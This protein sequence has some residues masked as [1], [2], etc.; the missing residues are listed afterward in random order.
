MAIGGALKCATAASAFAQFSPWATFPL[1]YADARV[2]PA[3]VLRVGFLPSYAN[4]D[5]RFGPG[6]TVRPLGA[7]LTSDT[8]GSNILWS[9]GTT[10]QAVRRI[11]GDSTYRATLGPIRTQLDADVRRIPLDLA[12]G[13]TSWLTLTARVSLVKTRMQAVV[14]LDSTKGTVGWNQVTSRANNA[15]GAAQIAALV[16]QLGTAVQTLESRIAGGSYGCPSSPEC[17][18]ATT[19]LTRARNLLLGLQDLSRAGAA[20][21]APLGTSPA[22][23]AMQAEIAAVKAALQNPSLGLPAVT[24]SY[25]FP[26]KSLTASDFQ[27]LLAD[28]AFGYQLRPLATTDISKLGDTDVGVRIGLLQR[29]SARVALLGTVRLPT[30]TLDSSDHL[31]DLGTGDKQWDVELGMEGALETGALGLSASAIY[32]RQFAHNLSLRLGG[33]GVPIR[34][35]SI[36]V[37][38]NRDPGDVLQL[39]AFPSIQLNRGFRVFLQAHYYRQSSDVY[40]YLGT[41]PSPAQPGVPGLAP[42]ALNLGGGIHYRAERTGG[43]EA[44]LPVEA[45]LSYQAA[46]RGSAGTPKS[47]ILNLYL[48]LHYQIY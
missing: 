9:I 32:T 38:Y 4:Y 45:G 18:Q 15:A 14:A 17:A 11:I 2:L 36:E 43:G 41:E 28:S 34:P 31:V 35:G 37:P 13:L 12:F 7:D 10:E 26:G 44:T 19:T 29:P 24:A 46:Y 25:A 42:S 6:Q 23:T 39:S 16:S 22:G 5:S 30:G 8:A 47:T 21:V 33:S 1:Q 20:P 48:R 3:G 40:D 27:T